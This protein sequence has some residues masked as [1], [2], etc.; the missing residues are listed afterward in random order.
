[1]PEKRLDIKRFVTIQA[2]IKLPTIDLASELSRK[3]ILEQEQ[4]AYCGTN[5][6]VC[7]AGV[8]LIIEVWRSPYLT[9]LDRIERTLRQAISDCGA[10]LLSMHL[11]EFSPNGGISGVG[12]LQESHISIHTWPEF[13]YAALDLF[14]CG[15]LDP[16]KALPALREGLAAESIQVSEIK[17]GILP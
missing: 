8:H 6:H 7:Y 10:T 5:G 15:T 9:D 2:A 12:V 17:R 14:V 13:D 1:M 11:H 4:T 16:Y 3:T